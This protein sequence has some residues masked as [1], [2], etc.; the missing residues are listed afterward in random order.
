MNLHFKCGIIA[1]TIFVNLFVLGDS[2]FETKLQTLISTIKS[3]VCQHLYIDLG[4]SIGIQIRKLYQPEYYKRAPIL[5]HYL[6]MFGSERKSVCAIGFEANPVHTNRLNNVQK[7]Y[8]DTGYHCTIFTETAVSTIDGNT[9]LYND[10]RNLP[11]LHEWGASL[12]FNPRVHRR[13]AN[14]T[15]HGVDFNKFF[16]KVYDAW[17]QTNTYS[18][19][20]SKVMVKVDVEGS[21][22][23]LLP[24]LLTGGS[25][26]KMNLVI[27]EWHDV[28]DKEK[29][30]EPELRAVISR[31]RHCQLEMINLDDETYGKGTDTAPF[32]TS[33]HI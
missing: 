2:N 28:P 24:H 14:V 25:L 3:G 19:T 22:H 8:N 30:I 12:E 29:S 16:L 9:T 17:T 23:E 4:S 33:I 13:E 27:S 31:A 26:C 32:P 7:A 18:P 11:I 10:D 5:Q 20:K 21:E 1:V 6:T 15:V